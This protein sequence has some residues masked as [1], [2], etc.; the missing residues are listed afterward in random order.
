LA[1]E[2]LAWQLQRQIV[3]FSA[4]SGQGHHEGMM[5]NGGG[6]KLGGRGTGGDDFYTCVISQIN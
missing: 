4:S 6:N 2:L 1:S 3:C 5:C